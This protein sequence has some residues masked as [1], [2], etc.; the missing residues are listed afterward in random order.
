[1]HCFSGINVARDQNGRLGV[2]AH[3]M[4]AGTGDHGFFVV[5]RSTF[6]RHDRRFERFQHDG[7]KR[8]FKGFL[9]WH[10]KYL[11]Q[12]F[13]F[14]NYELEGNPNSRYSKKKKGLWQVRV[15]GE[16][17]VQRTLADRVRFLSLI[18]ML[19]SKNRIRLGQA[20]SIARHGL[21]ELLETVASRIRQAQGGYWGDKGC[22]DLWPS[23]K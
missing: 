2:P 3:D 18:A 8:V 15:L 23:G 9:Y 1:M 21:P 4:L 11:K 6:F 10:L 16:A 13:G 17:E 5:G 19:S 22:P 14:G 12:D 20:R 7:M